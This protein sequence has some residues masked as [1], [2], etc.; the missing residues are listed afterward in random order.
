MEA[1]GYSG[2]IAENGSTD[3]QILNGGEYNIVPEI[4]AGWGSGGSYFF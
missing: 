3:I 4:N 1:D 2:G